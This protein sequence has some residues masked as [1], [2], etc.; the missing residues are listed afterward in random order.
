MSNVIACIDGSAVA[1]SVS[2]AAAWAARQLEAPAVLLHVL[3][4]TDHPVKGDLSGSIGFGSREHLLDELVEL[5]EKKSRLA[6]EHGKQLLEAAEARVTSLYG[7][8]VDKRQQHGSLQET[9][10]GLQPQSRL[11]VMGRRGEAHSDVPDSIGSNIETVVRTMQRPIMVVLPDFRPPERFMIA[12]D[13]SDTAQKALEMVARSPLLKGLECH[14]VMVCSN[15]QP[16]SR[17]RMDE[18]CRLLERSGFDVRKQLLEGEVIN[19]LH[20]YQEEHGIGLMVMGAYG[21]SRIRQFLVGSNTTKMVSSSR[22][23]L[24]LLR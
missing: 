17:R 16:D 7:G 21:H 15:P 18:A 23:P 9:L 6:L 2:D 13:A 24:L 19:A 11:L 12:Y 1:G 8:Q 4:K 20:S 5:E 14:V 22:I 3:E 10:Q